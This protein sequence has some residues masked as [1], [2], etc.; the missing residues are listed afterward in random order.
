MHTSTSLRMLMGFVV[1]LWSQYALATFHELKIDQ[2]YSNA[3]GS[4]QYVD[5][6]LPAPSDDERFLFGRTLT[7]GLNSHSLT[8]GSDLPSEPVAGQHF[9]VATPG[10]AAI[11]G[12]L[13]DY[14]F[15]GGPFFNPHGDTLVYA[16]SFDTFTFPALPADGIHA[17]NRNNTIAINAPINFAGQAGFVPEPASWIL[18]SIGVVGLGVALRRRDRIS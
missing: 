11:A 8:F 7:A 4:V 6:V 18:L 5:F 10:F 14:T 2:V 9:L 13:P 16:S 15:S 17:L 3:D 1:A 12:V